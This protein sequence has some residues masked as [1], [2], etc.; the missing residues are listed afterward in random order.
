MAAHAPARSPPKKAPARPRTAKP[1][2]K[3]AVGA[4]GD[5]FEHE[6]DRIAQRMGKS[7]G[8][9]APPPMLSSLPGV[10]RAVAPVAKV[11]PERKRDEPVKPPEQRTAKPGKA[12]RKPAS[13][14]SRTPPSRKASTPKGKAQRKAAAGKPAITSPPSNKGARGHGKPP[15]KAQ[16]AAKSEAP[17]AAEPVGH[18]GGDVPAQIERK[19]DSLRSRH[20]PGIDPGLKERVEQAAGADL[21]GARVHTGADAAQ[22][23]DALGARAF[24]VGNDMVFGRGEYQPR[25]TQG[26]MLIAHEAAHTVQQ[27]GGS[28]QAKRVVR[29]KRKKAKGAAKG[30]GKGKNDPKQ[31]ETP[32]TEVNE[33]SGKGWK[34][35][36]VSDAEK[37]QGTL[38]VEK[39]ELPL[40]AKKLKGEENATIGPASVSGLLPELGKPFKRDP[41]EDREQ[42]EDGAAYEKWMQFIR[43]NAENKIQDRLEKQI[44][45]QEKL[46]PKKAPAPLAKAGGDDVYVLRRKSTSA[47]LDTVMIGTLEQLAKHDSMVRPMIAKTG[48]GTTI[49]YYDADHILEDQ[50]GGLDAPTNMWLLDRSVNRSYGSQIKAGINDSIKTAL[51]KANAEAERAEEK[52]AKTF[53]GDIPDDPAVVKK[54]WTIVFGSVEHGKFKAGDD[55]ANF[56]TRTEVLKGDQVPAFTALTEVE[57]VQQ[58]F[59]TEDGKPKRINIFP[60][61]DGGRAASLEVAKDGKTLKPPKG[62]WFRGIELV[63]IASYTPEALTG[64][65]GAIA[66]IN[67]RKS[68]KADAKGKWEASNLIAAEGPVQVMHDPQLGF[69]GYIPRDSIRAAFEKAKFAPLSPLAFADIGINADGDLTGSGTVAS[70]KALLPGLQVPLSILGDDIFLSF[71]VPDKGL[72]LGPVNVDKAVINLGVGGNGFF[73][74]GIA[75]FSVQDVGRGSLSAR[76]EADDVILSGEFNLDLDFL[77]PASIAVTYSL[78]TDDFTAK[79]TLGV[80]KDAL[81]GI[82][83]GSVTVEITRKSFGL[84]GSLT[85]GGVLK[86]ATMTV[87]Y[88]PETGLVLEAKDIP[89]PV[90][91]LP[92][93]SEAALTVKA[94]RAAETGEWALSGGGKAKFGVAGASGELDILY[95]GVATSF[96]GRVDV[97]KGPASGWIEIRGTNRA[98]DDKGEPI[99][100]GPVGDLKIWGKGEA[101][102]TFGKVLKG[103][104]G[105]EYTP[106]GRVIIAGEIAM[107][108]TYDLFPKK[109]LSPE[110]P[111]I[112]IEPPAFPVWGVELGPVDIGILAFV[113]AT[114]K[115]E[116]WVGPGQLRDAKVSATM[117][118]DKPEEAVVDG[119]ATFFVPSY[120]GLDLYLGGGL[121]ASVAVAYVR[122]DVGLYGK[123]GLGVDGSF[124]VKVHWSQADGLAVGAE[125]KLEAK[126]KFEVGIRASV[127]AGVS[128]PW[129]LPD[130]D[131]TWGPWDHKL[132]EFGPDMALTAKFPMAWSEAE[133]LDLDP[134]KITIDPPKLDAKEL[135]KSGFDA[136]V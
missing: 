57:L 119:G 20:A 117:D 134:S 63:S 79:A 127:T 61:K 44:K 113:K 70:S 126:P 54:E 104:A 40:V 86:G 23:A 78:A 22:A 65:G 11:G 106:D 37:A 56:W 59:T 72:S 36:S 112:D 107:P 1:Q 42:R 24:T 64:G 136:L 95:D 121:K 33:L 7:D 125:A 47:T 66:T 82:E 105:I 50:L 5:R 52:E 130:L 76:A 13:S 55:P 97:A 15:A 123:L 129:P 14:P 74:E 10:Q 21:S 17:A 75:D 108:P 92:G 114:L 124:G 58:G 60:A 62:Y 81:P 89:L 29:M 102:I 133:G 48:K 26:Q 53:D 25:T 132:G 8:V 18:E 103:T 4:A 67:I 100:N 51:D 84:T 90:G 122:G 45:A 96:V 73:L 49:Q 19:I 68:K 94:V 110:K 128:L 9:S 93:V 16:R 135:M 3:M 32:A 6:A 87:G 77:D 35:S 2:A 83:T 91:K 115:A 69:G 80:Q 101:S 38:T 34:I 43:E 98:I 120:A 28:A 39:L 116:A 109:D 41:Q 12:Q 118:L 99:E 27:A 30:K 31:T 111:L 88:T 46:G 71:P 131:H 85:F